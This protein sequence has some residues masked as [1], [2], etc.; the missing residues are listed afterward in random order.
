[1]D[2]E[3]DHTSADQEQPQHSTLNK[4][5]EPVSTVTPTTTSSNS[6]SPTI[7]EPREDLFSPYKV[8]PNHRYRTRSVARLEQTLTHGTQIHE[9]SILDL[10]SSS[11]SV[12]YHIEDPQNPKNIQDVDIIIKSQTV[13][14]VGDTAEFPCHAVRPNRRH[15]IPLLE[16]LNWTSPI[17]IRK[18]H[19][20]RMFE[21]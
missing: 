13:Q 4:A 7:S 2:S 6:P 8:H 17:W 21:W 10:S 3:M 14:S 20:N 9:R 18:K 15:T 5:S 11:S 1:M 19:W 12:H 16:A